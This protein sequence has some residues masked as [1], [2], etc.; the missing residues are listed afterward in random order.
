MKPRT[1]VYILRRNGIWEMGNGKW[2]MDKMEKET[3]RSRVAYRLGFAIAV[4]AIS[5]VYDGVGRE[6]VLVEA[7]LSISWVDVAAA[8]A[9]E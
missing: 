1:Y 2:E 3:V 9:V 6:V 7:R 8:V 4:V 5:L